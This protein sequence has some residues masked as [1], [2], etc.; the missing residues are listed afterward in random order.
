MR[1]EIDDMIARKKSEEREAVLAEM[2]ALAAE[3][4]FEL[5]ELVAGKSKAKSKDK[6]PPK[7]R[8]PSDASQTWSGRGR[9]PNW[10]Q[11]AVK[12][13]AKLEDFAI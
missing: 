8:N 6:L 4:G 1:K 11:D 10:L 13:G 5:S 9:K 12:K 7:Y 2:K 3:R